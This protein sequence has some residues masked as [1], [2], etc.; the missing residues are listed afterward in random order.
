MPSSVAIVTLSGMVII[1]ASLPPLGAQPEPTFEVVSIKPSN[2]QEP[3]SRLAVLPGGRFIMTN[4]PVSAIVLTAYGLQDYFQADG[5]P[6]W[7]RTELF[8]VEAQAPAGVPI[9]FP[10]SGTALPRMLQAMLADRMR[11]VTHVET[12]TLP[13]FALVVARADRRLGPNL[14]RSQIDCSTASPG[15]PTSPAAAGAG[16]GCGNR[17]TFDSFSG[18]GIGLDRLIRFILAPRVGRQIVD[19]TGLAGT[20]DISLRFRPPEPLPGADARGLAVPDVN[21]DL[22]VIETALQ[23]QLGLKLEPIRE[24]SDVLIVDRIERPTMN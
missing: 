19:R 9:A 10:G 21:P 15:V 20:F 13:M 16:Q 3:G 7:S 17:A 24:P 22:P 14:V 18:R 11:L 5:F 6:E 2:P 12:R 1:G 8:D 4:A 23:E